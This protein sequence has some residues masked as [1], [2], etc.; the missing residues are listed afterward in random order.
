MSLTHEIE[1]FVRSGG[2]PAS[3]L[4]RLALAAFAYQFERIEAYRA[5]C[6]RRG[7]TLV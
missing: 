4:E 1:A 3:E 7:A 5:L 6:E 2:G